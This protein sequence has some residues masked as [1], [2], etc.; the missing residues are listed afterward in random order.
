MTISPTYLQ[1][2]YTQ[3]TVLLSWLPTGG[4]TVTVNRA[5]LQFSSVFSPI[6]LE[7]RHNMMINYSVDHD[8]NVKQMLC[9]V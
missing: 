8:D 9:P 6:W 7:I 2:L 1:T 5:M 4:T 3:F